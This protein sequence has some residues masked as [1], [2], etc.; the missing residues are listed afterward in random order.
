MRTADSSSPGRYYAV[1][2]GT[3]GSGVTGDPDYGIPFGQ[4]RL[5]PIWVATLA[6]RQ[7]SRTVHFQSAAK[8]LEEFDLPKVGFHYRRLVDGFKRVFR[9][10]IYFGTDTSI[11]KREVWDCERFHFFDRLRIWCSGRLVR[12]WSSQLHVPVQPELERGRF[13]LV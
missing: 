6:V 13:P 1:H 11:G 3:G 9:S 10:T 12:I 2:A 5:I 8:I 7:K 4:D